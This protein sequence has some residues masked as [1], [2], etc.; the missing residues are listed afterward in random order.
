LKDGKICV[1]IEKERLTRRKHDGGN[2]TDTVQYCLETEG[3]RTEDLTLVVQNANFGMLEAGNSWWEGP[4]NL[5]ESVPVV[6][7]SHHLAHAYSSIGTCPFEEAAVLVIDGCGNALDECI[8]LPSS[9]PADLPQG[10]LRQVYF[11]KDSYYSFREGL[12]KPVF[13]DF[14]PW[15]ISNRGN[16]IFPNTTMHSVGGLYLGVS[17]YVFNGFDDAG[18]LMGLAPY[19]RPGI[20]N[21]DIFEL[22]DGRAFVR[23]DWMSKFTRPARSHQEFKN[24][25]QYYADLAWWVQRELERA[26]LYVVKSRYE[27]A[28]SDNLAYSGGVALNAVANRRILLESPFKRLYIQ[29]A[30]GDNGLAIGC[31]YYGWMN[32]LGKERVA[33]SGSPFLGRSYGSG[34]AT[35]AISVARSKITVMDCFDYIQETAKYLAD[36]KVVAWFQNGSEFGPRALGNRSILADPRNRE[37]RPFINAKIKFREDFRPFAPS[38]PLDDARQY[39][40]SAYESP[41]MILVDRVHPEWEQSIPSVVH[42]DSSARIQTVTREFNPNYYE[43]LKAFQELTGISVL[44]NTSLNRRGMPIVE[45]PEEA[46]NFFL[47]CDLDVLVLDGLILQKSLRLVEQPDIRELFTKRIPVAL[48]AHGSLLDQVRG[49]YR[50]KIA[51]KETWTIDLRDKPKV[52]EGENGLVADVSLE[53]EEG[54]LKQLIAD[55]DLEGPKLYAANKIHVDGS[56]DLAANV[57]SIFRLGAATALAEDPLLTPK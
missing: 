5:A 54:I 41:Y 49:V 26:I 33:H 6:T 57:M 36:G 24:N 16:P 53:I 50:F 28:P 43:L 3:I 11:E 45:T 15:G 25:F 4:R 20:H 8:D 35:N 18:K 9:L 40:D 52:I 17:T 44:L 13:K 42:R 7:I 32:V 29:P 14:S 27:M 21:F 34:K 12:L 31:A 39:F 19:G 23:Y 2:D 56:L 51:T 48:A 38:V 10:E 46:I 37:I 30:A 22:R 47:S 55:P 1:A